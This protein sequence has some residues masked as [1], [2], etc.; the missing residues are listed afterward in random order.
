MKRDEIDL[1]KV[2][3]P[4]LFKMYLFP[5]LL[6]MLS[7]CAVTATDGIFVGQGV[8]SDALAAVNICIAP[9]MLLMG[10]GLM[11]GVGSSVV[12]SVHL[13]AGNIK[14]AR[15][16]ITQAM[17]VGTLAT[18]TFLLITLINP[19]F[20]G[21]ILGSSE[22]LMP[23]VKDYMPWIFVCCLWQIWCVIG[24]FVVRL[25]GSPR[26]AMWCNIIPGVLNIFLDWLFIFPLHKGLWGAAVA[27]CLSCLVGGLMVMAYMLFFSRRLTFIKIKFSTKSLWLTVR[28]IIYQCKIGASALLGEAT[29]GMIMLMGNLVFMRYLGNDGVAAFSIAC[30]YCPFVFMIGNAIA[31]S[32]QPIIS[33]NY[34]LKSNSRVIATERLAIISAIICGAIVTTGFVVFP[35]AM[36][37]LFL[38]GDSPAAAIAI[39]G[40]PEFSTAFVFFIFNMTAIGYFQSVEKVI[41][42]IVFALLRGVVFLV[43]A[44]LLV[45]LAWGT[46]GIWEALFVSEALTTLCIIGY[47]FY[48]RVHPQVKKQRAEKPHLTDAIKLPIEEMQEPKNPADKKFFNIVLSWLEKNYS[49]PDLKIID[50]VEATG[51]KRSAFYSKL[52]EVTGLSPIDFVTCVRLRKACRLLS[53]TATPIADIAHAVGYADSRYF[54]RTFKQSLGVSPTDY[55]SRHKTTPAE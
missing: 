33:Y 1:G 17:A 3:I 28:N 20:T 51:M 11:L 24:L 29:M 16:N 46:E 27:T 25:D 31:Q 5:T 7:L 47:Y 40:F 14:A 2:Q 53:T 22:S 38:P 48:H 50:M 10:I 39:E 44:F 37:L 45:P 54:A 55:R 19:E 12:S 49:N 8:G 36:V 35:R 21:R 9:T 15:L 6:G 32:A 13:S 42:A 18:L 26:Y 30:Y 52:K 23:L 34:G 41:P 4:R 43:P